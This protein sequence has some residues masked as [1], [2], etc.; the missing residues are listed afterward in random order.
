MKM[1]KQKKY[2]SAER[3]L[4]EM[5]DQSSED[6][7]ALTQLANVLWNQYKDEEALH[8]ANMAKKLSSFYPLLNYTRGRILWSLERYEQSKE[9]WDVILNM[10]ET[11][12]AK[13]GFGLGWSKSVINDSRYYKADCLYH[14]YKDNEALDLM[15]KHLAHRGKGIES[16]FTKKEAVLFYKVLKYSHHSEP[17]E[18]TDEDYASESQ[19]NRIS[20]KIDDMEKNKDWKRMVHYLKAKCKRYP[21]EYY[22]KIILSKYCRMLGN[23]AECL[24]FAEEAFVQEPYDPLVKYNYAI[25]LMING[26]ADEALVQFKEIVALGVDYIAFSEHGEGMKWAKKLLRETQRLIKSLNRGDN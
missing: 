24:T 2:K 25:G 4:R 21:K 20:K 3:I 6:V 26:Q 7:Y 22:L 5:L 18:I 16:D 13:S 12:I 14:L 9:E 1:I 19:R 10:P 23:K 17:V 8:Y 11:E 15:E